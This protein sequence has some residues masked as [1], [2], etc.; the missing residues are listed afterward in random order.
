MRPVFETIGGGLT[1]MPCARTFA[2]MNRLPLVGISLLLTG[3]LGCGGQLVSRSSA[4]VLLFDA[5]AMRIHPIFTQVKDW[6]GDNKPD[7]LEALIEFEDQFDDSTKAA[8]RVIFELFEYR[9]TSPESRGRRV[10]G[11]WVASIQSTDEQ[12]QRWSRTTQSY[13]FQL[14]DPGIRD[15]QSYVLSAIFELSGGGRFFDRIVLSG[16]RSPEK[17]REQVLRANGVAPGSRIPQP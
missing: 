1:D 15:D 14:N 12:R 10:A 6:T 3:L 17:D 8:G 13:S 4:P 9:K 5:R 7:G 11:P 2:E 16:R